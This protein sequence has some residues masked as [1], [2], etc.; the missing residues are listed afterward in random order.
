MSSNNI[1][2]VLFDP[3]NWTLYWVWSD[4]L[5]FLHNFFSQFIQIGR[6]VFAY[7]YHSYTSKP[8]QKKVI[9]TKILYVGKINELFLLISNRIAFSQESHYLC[10]DKVRS[11]RVEKSKEMNRSNNY[12]RFSSLSVGGFHFCVGYEFIIGIVRIIIEYKIF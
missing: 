9:K 11:Q 1:V 5:F 6:I 7:F 12:I 10:M 8:L 3:Y 2:V 4:C